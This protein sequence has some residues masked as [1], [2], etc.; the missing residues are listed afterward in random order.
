M[1]SRHAQ[2]DIHDIHQIHELLR[3]CHINSLIGW[4]IDNTIYEPDPLFSDLGSDQWFASLLECARQLL[5]SKNDACQVSITLF[6]EVHY[7]ISVKPV[8]PKTVKMIHLLQDVNLPTLAITA[9]GTDILDLTMDQL[10]Q[11]DIHFSKQWGD[12]SFELDIGEKNDPPY[13]HHGVIFCNGHDK[14]TCLQ[15]FAKQAA[16][17]YER[18]NLDPEIKQYAILTLRQLSRQKLDVILVDDKEKNLHVVKALAKRNGWSYTGLRYAHLDEKVR[19]FDMTKATHQL[20]QMQERLSFS[21]RAAAKKLEIDTLHQNTRSM[22]LLQ[23]HSFLAHH[24]IGR[25]VKGETQEMTER[26]MNSFG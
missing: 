12:I 5:D 6:R 24:R 4:D 22:T 17:H 16:R 1:V 18:S 14:G 10:N 2:S 21:G 8:E 3:E 13:F 15:A 23:R 26:L 25:P 7:L 19:N 11:I 20:I 9:R